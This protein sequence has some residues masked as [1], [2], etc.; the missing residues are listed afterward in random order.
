MRPTFSNEEF[1]DLVAAGLNAVPEKFLKRLS[2]VA[3]VVEDEPT[4]A[5]R[6]KLKL[7]RDHELFGLYEG[8]PQ[9]ARGGSYHWVL[10]DK[11]TIFRRPI[12]EHAASTDEVKKM[13]RDTVW[14][15]LAHHFGI[16]E[17]EV[18]RRERKRR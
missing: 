3:M 18:R 7:R 8:I 4:P 9:T 16:D 17:R 2:N 1:D 10:P 14:H 5:Q 11:I 12:L 13:V 15:E 6:Q